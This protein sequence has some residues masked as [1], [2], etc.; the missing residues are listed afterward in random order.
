LQY[1]YQI[2]AF[3]DGTVDHTGAGNDASGAYPLGTHK[4]TFKVTDQCGNWNTCTKLFTILDCQKPTPICI[5]GLSVDLMPVPGGGMAIIWAASMEA[6]DSHDNCTDYDDLIILIERYSA[7]TPGQEEPGAG[8]SD[9]LQVTCDDRPP[10]TPN[11]IIEVVVWVGDSAG[12]WDYCIATVWVQDNMGIC[13]LEGNTTVISSVFNPDQEAMNQVIFEISGDTTGVFQSQIDGNAYLTNLPLG[14]AVNIRPI[15]E[16]DPINGVSTLDL[17]LMLKHITGIRFKSP[18]EWMAADVD[19]NGIISLNDVLLLRK[20][21]LNP[22][23]VPVGYSSWRFIDAG[24]V[25]PGMVYDHNYPNTKAFTG[26]THGL[27]AEFMGV[28]IGDVSGDAVPNV[29]NECKTMDWDGTLSFEIADKQL[30]KGETHT[31]EIRASGFERIQGYQYTLDFDPAMMEFVNVDAQWSDLSE[32]NF[33]LDRVNGGVVTTSWNSSEPV[34]LANDEVLYTLTI[35]A[36]ADLKLSEVMTV[37][38]RVT[39]AEAYDANEDLL[40]VNF[41]FDGNIVAGGAFEL[42]QNEPNPFRD[43]TI[44]GFNLPE[45]SSAVLTVYDI[46]GAVIKVVRG[47]Y[48]KGY[49]TV[50]LNRSEI[51]GNGMLYYSLETAT[52]RAT[53]RMIMLD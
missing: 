21:I 9:V 6:G 26:L 48:A 22:E 49:N 2:D 27:S 24:Y 5:N 15:K 39:R 45:S 38:S 18:Y 13:P 31:I 4:I 20:L 11:G 34:S 47:D 36:K 37:N 19:H 52:D 1:S 33:G 17:Q 44:I 32:A 16:D 50:H 8:A 35:R 46:T 25:F 30:Q 41:R 53:K 42:Y 10:T 12:N 29:E 51:Q 28:K 23:Q 40:E 43:M 7:I 3:N 14:A